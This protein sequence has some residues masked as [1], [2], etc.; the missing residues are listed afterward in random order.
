MSLDI[1][2]WLQRIGLGQYAGV[3]RS[4]DIDGTLLRRLN[5]DDLK[6]MGVAALGH[7][8]KLLDAIAAL[9][10]A[11]ESAAAGAVSP[12]PV[13]DASTRPPSVASS[14]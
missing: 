11:P 10:H 6:E 1:P 3:F 7:R 8:K 4:N 2:P 12:K 14:P 5:G 13:A 9:G